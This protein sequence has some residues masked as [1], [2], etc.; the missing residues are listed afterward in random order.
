V[1]SV[2]TATL[3]ALRYVRDEKSEAVQAIARQYDMPVEQAAA[4]YD[5]SRDTWSASGRLSQSAYENSL[6]PAEL[7]NALPMDRVVD[8]RFVDG[9]P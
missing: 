5:L 9:A 8:H 2:V 3:E 7:A 4:A 6:D 1:Q